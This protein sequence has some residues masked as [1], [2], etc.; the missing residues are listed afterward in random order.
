MSRKITVDAYQTE[1]NRSAVRDVVV[2]AAAKARDHTG[3]VEFT[4]VASVE[5]DGYG[6]FVVTF[7]RPQIAKKKP[8]A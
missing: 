8:G 2:S 1:L 6:G 3:N 4:T 7:I 5:E